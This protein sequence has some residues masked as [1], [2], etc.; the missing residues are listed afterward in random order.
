M[1]TNASAPDVGAETTNSD[2]VGELA[3]SKDALGKGTDGGPP[4]NAVGNEGPVTVKAFCPSTVP[5]RPSISTASTYD[6]PRV[7]G[8]IPFGIT[9]WNARVL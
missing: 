3:T 7:E 1:V 6:D 5:A 2:P 8:S 9:R 4:G